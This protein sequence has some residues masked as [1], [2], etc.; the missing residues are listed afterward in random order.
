MPLAFHE[1]PLPAK[2]ESPES[3]L[4]EKSSKGG[5]PQRCA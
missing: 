4:S 2:V 3:R 1:Y 5:D